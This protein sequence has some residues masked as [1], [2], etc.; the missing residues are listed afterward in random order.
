MEGN[1]PKKES[2]M[3]RNKNAPMS[4]NYRKGG[5]SYRG[6]GRSL[7]GMDSSYKKDFFNNPNTRP[8]QIAEIQEGLGQVRP[9]MYTGGFSGNWEKIGPARPISPK[10]TIVDTGRRASGPRRKAGPGGRAGGGSTEVGKKVQSYKEYVKKTFGG[11][12]T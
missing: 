5:K 4:K 10:E 9:G 11:G 3:W 2:G 7:L 12:K 8:P 6:G 1:M